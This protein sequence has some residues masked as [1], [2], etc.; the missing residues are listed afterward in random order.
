MSVQSFSLDS[1]SLSQLDRLIRSH[2]DEMTR[3]VGDM[4]DRL[5][6]SGMGSSMG[7]GGIRRGA[8]R[9]EYKDE[10]EKFLKVVKKVGQTL[11]VTEKYQKDAAERE[12]ASV[13]R[14]IQADKDAAA[15]AEQNTEAQDDNTE[16]SQRNTNALQNATDQL[17]NWAR[18][19]AAGTLSFTAVTRAVNEFEQ[20][21]K[22]GL[23]W[24]ALS[25]TLH[26]AFTMGL[27]PKDM[28]DFQ[29]KFRRVSNTFADGIEGFNKVA[30]ANQVEWMKYT[31][32]LKEAAFMQGEFTDVALSMGTG[33]KDVNGAVNTMFERFK[34]LQSVTS[35]TA[36]QFVAMQRSMLSEQ[37]VRDKLV[38]LQGKERLNYM[39]GLTQTNMAFRMMGMQQEVADRLVKFIEAQSTKGARTR[40]KEAAQLSVVA[41]TL[42]MDGEQAARLAA[43]H[44]KRN[45]TEDEKVE[46]ARLGQVLKEAQERYRGSGQFNQG[47]A[48]GEYLVD[49]LS[50]IAPILNEIGNAN[51]DGILSSGAE[52]NSSAIARQQ[53][54]IADRNEGLQGKIIES[55][56]K[57]SNM[58]S[59]WGA[60]ALAALVGGTFAAARW[61]R[62][63]FGGGG[64]GGA[65]GGPGGAGGGLRRFGAGLWGNI[66]KYGRAGAIGLGVGLLGG[67]A[68]AIADPQSE[69]KKNLWDKG[70]MGAGF[71]AAIG[72]AIAPGIGTA[73]GAAI[74][75]ALGIG[76]AY[77]ENEGAFDDALTKQKK[78]IAE[79]AN[80]ADLKFKFDQDYYNREIE[81]IKKI[82]EAR[83][84]VDQ[85]Q[86]DRLEQMKAASKKEYE[87]T[88]AKNAVDSFAYEA[89]NLIDAKN[90]FAQSAKDMGGSWGWD[91]GTTDD[92]SKGLA[93]MKGRLSMAGVEIS[94]EQ[95][96][97]MLAT[98][99]QQAAIESNTRGADVD[100][101]YNAL[102]T[103]ANF[104]YDN[105]LIN[106]LIGQAMDKLIPQLTEQMSS[107]LGA[108]VAERFKTPEQLQ[109]LQ[110][111]IEDIQKQVEQD[112][113]II[114]AAKM[115]P[116]MRTAAEAAEKRIQENTE[117]AGLLQQLVNDK[118][119]KMDGDTTDLFTRMAESLEKIA[120]E[121]KKFTAARSRA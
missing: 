28:M 49:A 47:I 14:R 85:A 66:G 62:G 13:K 114:D 40:L 83:G 79:Q 76:A 61:G 39:A 3:V 11:T 86:L 17:G 100:A 10:L 54:E 30:S 98:T 44:R 33:I 48:S 64:P 72:S 71:G 82:G 51:T 2:R 119:V 121:G 69:S 15:A 18:G 7:L 91:Y 90:S 97:Q 99:F 34:H 16:S 110:G 6:G 115:N 9:E 20:A 103:G 23:N 60:S 32:N 42:G 102:K 78:A 22:T 74:G 120:G 57:F 106:P 81:R 68:Q 87:A 88:S 107:Q 65:G 77:L 45:K 1:N 8:S 56:V 92:V 36:E 70:T 75:G 105:G 108:S 94:D 116:H 24:N 52:A 112:K 55:I 4:L 118:T 26:S 58:F 12:L 53:A 35:M 38:G 46:Y 50:S 59:A 41:Q 67:A 101:T 21:Y 109:T 96:R 31:G 27:S 95:L 104:D 19:L 73:V 43:L 93:G 25:D 63:A 80:A 117:L 29:A 37:S 5:S 111:N 113:N 89:R 84:E